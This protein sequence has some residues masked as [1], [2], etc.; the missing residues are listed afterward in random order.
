MDFV[1]SGRE[2]LNAEMQC[3]LSRNSP[4]LV[5]WPSCLSS[6]VPA[7]P[8]VTPCSRGLGMLPQH[9]WPSC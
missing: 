4:Q 5:S 8:S 6:K 7:M 9:T 1:R 2:Y 3:L